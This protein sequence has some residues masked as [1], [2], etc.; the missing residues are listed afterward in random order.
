MS[1][2]NLPPD[3]S[4][5]SF[6]Q[7][8][9][10][11]PPP[12]PPTPPQPPEDSG[13][14]EKPTEVGDSEPSF[15]EQALELV[16]EVVNPLPSAAEIIA[17]EVDQAREDRHRLERGRLLGTD[18]QY[19][20]VKQIGRGGM[21][22][23]YEGEDTILKRRVAIKVVF[24]DNTSP[25]GLDR[26]EKEARDT[27]SLHPHNNVVIYKCGQEP[28]FAWIAMEYLEGETLAQRIDREAPISWEEVKK[29]CKDVLAGLGDVHSKGRAHCDIKPSNVMCNGK[30]WK[31]L[32]LGLAKAVSPVTGVARE[33]STSGTAAYLATRVLGGAGQALFRAFRFLRPGNHDQLYAHRSEAGGSPPRRERTGGRRL[34]RRTPSNRHASAGEV[35]QRR[36]I[37]G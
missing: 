33:T 25:G 29:I 19:R 4:T 11:P 23:V 35:W 3:D 16:N 22:V 36:G 8:P 37:S 27:A 13:S 1:D 21:A 7:P 12:E 15:G 31:I 28:G 9:L 5:R 20:I 2:Q 30:T 14:G 17:E 34:P 18:G 24:A 32:D 6:I 26:L 10:G